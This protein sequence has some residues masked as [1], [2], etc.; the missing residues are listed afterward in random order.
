MGLASVSWLSAVVRRSVSRTREVP[1]RDCVHYCAFRYGRDELHPYEHY[2]RG[3]AAGLPRDELR[4]A[5]VDFLR[6]YRPRTLGD[7]L[8][9][10][11]SRDYP[12]WHLPWTL[13]W[14]RTA[15][16]AQP[17]DVVDVMTHFSERGIPSQV[18]EREYALHERA[19]ERISR[20]GY[21]PGLLRHARVVE[22]QGA[23]RSAYLVTD[24]NHRIGAL[25][26]L[27][28][29]TVTVSSVLGGRVVRARAD[30]WPLVRL[31]RMT[32]ADALAVF[33]AYHE[34]N[35]AP[36]RSEFPAEVVTR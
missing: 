3:L 7:A 8:G 17:T 24:G 16:V 32:L 20:E 14:R 19:F 25:S 4:A 12:L 26:A 33:D 36:P 11:L 28:A 27:G 1:I 6:H 23:S 35:R 2:E 21:R 5:F 34:G 29:R 15:W 13:G 10:R 31:G 30:R 9:L 18:V 22:L